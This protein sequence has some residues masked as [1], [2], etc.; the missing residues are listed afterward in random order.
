MKAVVNLDGT[1][2]VEVEGDTT[3]ELFEEIAKAQEVFGNLQ[4]KNKEGKTSNKV[5]LRVRTDKDDNKYYEAVCVDENQPELRWAKFTFGCHKKG[6]GLFPK[7]KNWV[8]FDKDSGQEI[9]LMTGKPVDKK[10]KD[11]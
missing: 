11:E 9:D 8:K 7:H 1:F 4:V 6:G 10:D 2:S 3:Q 5:V